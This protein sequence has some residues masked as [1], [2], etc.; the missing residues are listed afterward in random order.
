MVITIMAI[1]KI[2]L[3]YLGNLN[4]A[5]TWLMHAGLENASAQ[6]AGRNERGKTKKLATA[7][8]QQ[9]LICLG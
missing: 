8:L 1:S 5:R 6:I 2:L 4:G 7:N 9:A 3:R